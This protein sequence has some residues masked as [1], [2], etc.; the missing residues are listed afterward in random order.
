MTIEIEG[1]ENG[2]GNIIKVSEII[3]GEEILDAMRN[4]I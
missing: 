1:L 3:S 4:Q 2:L